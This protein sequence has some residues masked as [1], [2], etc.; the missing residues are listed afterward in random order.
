MTTIFNNNHAFSKKKIPEKQSKKIN[1]QKK[2]T[3]RIVPKYSN[4]S[5]V[6]SKF[7]MYNFFGFE[8]IRDVK[9]EIDV[10]KVSIPNEKEFSVKLKLLR[11]KKKDYIDAKTYLERINEIEK[12]QSK[13]KSID[14]ELFEAINSLKLDDDK[15][16]EKNNK[17]LLIKKKYQQIK[18]LLEFLEKN[19]KK[20]NDFKDKTR[21]I[22]S[23]LKISIYINVL[24]KNI[25]KLND[26]SDLKFEFFTELCN[27]K[28]IN[29][30]L[31]C[32]NNY[33]NLSVKNDDILKKIFLSNEF[34]KPKFNIE[35]S[36]EISSIL[37]NKRKVLNLDIFNQNFNPKFFKIP[38]KIELKCKLEN[39][40]GQKKIIKDIS[41]NISIDSINNEAF[42][43][44]YIEENISLNSSYEKISVTRSIEKI[45][46]KKNLIKKF[47]IIKFNIKDKEENEKILNFFKS[48]ED[49]IFFDVDKNNNIKIYISL[50]T[51]VSNFWKQFLKIKDK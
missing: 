36:E 25:K 35:L 19:K 7:V 45:E 23:T 37:Y 39:K 13:I 41:S 47:I 1:I 40:K 27:K 6:F 38:L 16:K 49:L 32:E 26:N 29:D 48:K 50:Y 43:K 42:F 4:D 15:I 10:F 17:K 2:F 21:K 51:L 22:N 46:Y 3:K 12:I 28:T 11:N 18:N 44:N 33:Y 34:K 14:N 5:D 24:S 20:V 9:V 8:D 30:I 31:I